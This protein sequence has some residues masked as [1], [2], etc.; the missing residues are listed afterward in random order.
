[1]VTVLKGALSRCHNRLCI[2]LIISRIY[3]R[4]YQPSNTVAL[5]CPLREPPDPLRIFFEGGRSYSSYAF[6]TSVL[7][8]VSGQRHDPAQLSSSYGSTAQIVPWPPLL[9]FRNKKHFTGLDC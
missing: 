3:I 7:G 4:G 9:G 8:G 2:F 6:L 1:M 5:D